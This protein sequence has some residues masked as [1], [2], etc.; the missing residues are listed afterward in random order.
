MNSG[1]P[2]RKQSDMNEEEEE[3]EEEVDPN[4][5]DLQV[6]HVCDALQQFE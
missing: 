1:A 2:G 6:E 4:A 5:L 3:E